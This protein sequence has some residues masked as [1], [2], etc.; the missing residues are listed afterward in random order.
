MKYCRFC[1]KELVEDRC[2]CLD[3]RRANDPESG[4]RRLFRDP[5]LIPSFKVNTKSVSGFISSIRDLSGMSEANSGAGDPYEYNVPIVPDCIEP[6]ADEQVVKQYNIA[7][8]RTRL[9]FMKA[10]G[11][12]M[13]TNR[14]ILFRAAGTSLT[15]NLLQEHQYNLDDISGVELHK[16]YK[17][18]L[19]NL[20]GSL[21]LLV[22]GYFLIVRSIMHE[23]IN[24][25]ST[26]MCILTGLLGMVPTFV[27]YK[28]FWLKLLCSFVSTSLL[29]AI[30]Y[31]GWF[32]EL[33]AIL[34]LII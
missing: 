2:D 14:R 10:E 1:G 21:L 24:G 23:E 6:E 32:A 29:F 28:R 4:K 31:T 3:W 15:G 8:L 27:V 11:R 26:F 5:L 19:M 30:S 22:L 7:R 34:A 9:K 17:F 12:L 33:L 16:D 20:L 25:F 13:V 18:S